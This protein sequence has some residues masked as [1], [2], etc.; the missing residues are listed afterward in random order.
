V[1][2]RA[3]GAGA[4]IRTLRTGLETGLTKNSN[5]REIGMSAPVTLAGVRLFQ[6]ARAKDKTS[7]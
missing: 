1:V 5:H 4:P 2:L 6:E 7:G 3:A